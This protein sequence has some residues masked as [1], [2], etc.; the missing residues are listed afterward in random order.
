MSKYLFNSNIH[1]YEA[2]N[3]ETF[4]KEVTKEDTLIFIV[5]KTCDEQTS[6]YYKLVN[7]A[8]MN[9]AKVVLIS[10]DD[11]NRTSG[12][13]A[14][15]MLVYGAYGIY[16]IADRE[17]LSANY[18]IKALER[19]PDLDEAKVFVDNEVV[20]YQDMVT[21]LYG[22]QSLVS[23]GNI[24]GLTNHIERHVTSI[25][26][27]VVT[28]NKMKKV[29]ELFNSDELLDSI[30]TLKKTIDELHD[31]LNDKEKQI[32]DV[33]HNRDEFKVETEG[34]KR[35]LAKVKS[36]LPSSNESG[37]EHVI[38]NY[39]AY[40]TLVHGSKVNI[41]YFKEISYVRYTNTLISMLYDKLD[42]LKKNCKLLI[43]DNNNSFISR[44]TLDVVNG[45]NYASDKDNIIKNKKK[46]VITEPFNSVL[47]DLTSNPSIH[48]LIIYDRL[49]FY[50]DIITGN[51][52]TK[53]IVVNSAK[54]LEMASK[55]KG[56]GCDNDENIITN[57]NNKFKYDDNKPTNFLDIP[58]IA[59]N[60]S[61]L[62][63][64]A[65]FQRYNKL[66]SSRTH[67]NL[68]NTILKKAHIDV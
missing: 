6:K 65:Q 52:V 45:K 54:D 2:S 26:G 7:K 36:S 66:I 4:D 47:S 10:I 22:I 46:M 61:S 56:L 32:E 23:E 48:T 3:I 17:A 21:V 39:M 28:L 34:L 64:A 51:C 33:K 68:L 25:E 5:D 16:K 67:V 9:Q 8:L 1:G 11:C 62:S 44:Y 29:C 42:K 13:L 57:L 31:T 27:M 24:E 59:E 41:I 49:G 14:S 60:F 20:A 37:S 12:V 40:N 15:N 53:F 58:S 18:I 35:E 43:Y 55:I 38:K 63:D 50:E 30:A 19:E